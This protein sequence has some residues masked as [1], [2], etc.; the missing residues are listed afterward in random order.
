MQPSAPPRRTVPA[1]ALVVCLLAGRAVA[2]A[3]GGLPDGLLEVPSRQPVTLQEAFWE[4]QADGALWLR[5][6]FIAPRIGSAPGEY[7]FDLVEWDM[8]H[9]CETLGLPWADAAGAELIVVSLAA[10]AVE[11]GA[12]TPDV[13]QFFEAYRP[14]DGE[15]LWEEY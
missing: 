5:L 15:C 12:Q 2:Q 9:L 1:I 10:E 6:R 3:E 7:G 4:E 14:E 11:F 13:A 8:V